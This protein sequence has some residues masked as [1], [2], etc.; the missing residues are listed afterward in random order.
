MTTGQIVLYVLIAVVVGAYLWRWVRFRSV[1]QYSA[2]EVAKKLKENK[3]TVLLDVRTAQERGRKHIAGSVHMPLRELR[4]RSSELERHKNKEVIC[5]CQTGSRSLSA[6]ATL[7][8]MGFTAASM[9]GGMV[10]WR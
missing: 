6:A 9:K 5:Y 7:G 1:R 8:K 4:L 10:E 2:A 3:N